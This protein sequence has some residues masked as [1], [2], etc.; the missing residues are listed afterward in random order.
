VGRILSEACS[1]DKHYYLNLVRNIIKLKTFYPEVVFSLHQLKETQQKQ[2]RKALI[3]WSINA[4]LAKNIIG[5]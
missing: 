4:I 1:L 2:L 5:H 3:M